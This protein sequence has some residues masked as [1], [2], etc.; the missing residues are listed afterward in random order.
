M[1]VACGI[2]CLSH[3]RQTSH[4]NLV[5]QT[6]IQRTRPRRKTVFFKTS[7]RVVVQYLGK[8]NVFRQKWLYLGKMVAFG[9]KWLFWGKLVVFGQNWFYWEKEL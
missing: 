3:R 8:I 5:D 7:L 2:L 9:Q 1:F 4:I 6:H